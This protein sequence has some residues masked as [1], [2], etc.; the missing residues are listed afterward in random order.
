MRNKQKDRDNT[1]IPLVGNIP[2]S[3][4]KN[5]ISSNKAFIFR[6]YRSKD[7]STIFIILGIVIF[8][9]VCCLIVYFVINKNR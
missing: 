4:Y 5:G 7:K 6:D 8:V 3:D 1:N 9:I 2:P